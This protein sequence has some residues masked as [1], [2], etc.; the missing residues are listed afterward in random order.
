[1]MLDEGAFVTG[2]GYPWYPRDRRVDA[3]CQR[4]LAV[5]PDIPSLPSASAEAQ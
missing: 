2:F 1:M 5:P 4:H 3:S